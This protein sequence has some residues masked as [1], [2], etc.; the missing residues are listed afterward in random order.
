RGHGKGHVATAFLHLLHFT[1]VVGLSTICV[2][3]YRFYTS[4]L[5]D[6]ASPEGK[7]ILENAESSRARGVYGIA[8]AARLV[9]VGEQ[10]L[11]LYER[12]GLG[13]P[14]RTTG[15]TRRYSENDL[16]ILRRVVELLDAGVNLTGARHVLALE[17]TN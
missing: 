6:N 2:E 4:N 15:G 11:R 10:A 13:E 7:R 16:S 3:W 14:G 5:T 1:V 12:K 8:V 9:A 17:T